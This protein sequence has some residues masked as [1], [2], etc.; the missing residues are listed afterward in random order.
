MGLLDDCL[1]EEADQLEANGGCWYP[2]I[3]VQLSGQD[4]N[5]FMIIARVERELRRAGVTPAEVG[6]FRMEAMSGNYDHV[7]QTAMNWVTV[8]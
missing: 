2:E 5:A 1:E 3:E 4:G 8:Y 7:L 6:E